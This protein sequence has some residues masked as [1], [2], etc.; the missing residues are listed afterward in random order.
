MST[1]TPDSWIERHWLDEPVDPSYNPCEE[2]ECTHYHCDGCARIMPEPTDSGHCVLC[3]LEFAAQHQLT[4]PGNGNRIGDTVAPSDSSQNLVVS[5][6]GTGQ[7]LSGGVER[8]AGAKPDSQR[9][10]AVDAES[11]SSTCGPT[12]EI[13]DGA[14][15]TRG[16]SAPPAQTVL[17]H[18]MSHFGAITK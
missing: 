7:N 12:P 18:F 17:K 14:R 8:L 10:H 9:R 5:G 4:F 15:I 16:S 2:G 1:H 6:N 13:G 11:R 3:D